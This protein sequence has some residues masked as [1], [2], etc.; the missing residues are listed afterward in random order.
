MHLTY[1]MDGKQGLPSFPH[2][3]RLEVFSIVVYQLMIAGIPIRFVAGD[4]GFL[5]L[6]LPFDVFVDILSMCS[7]VRPASSI[8][9]IY[10]S[11][12]LG[13]SCSLL[14]SPDVLHHRRISRSLSCARV[15]SEGPEMIDLVYA[16]SQL[17]TMFKSNF[18]TIILEV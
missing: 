17:N 9:V 1:L 3:R 15:P 5:P 11:T 16:I 2:H 6:P 4:A 13:L 8:E 18:A 10:S 7:N 14:V 12:N